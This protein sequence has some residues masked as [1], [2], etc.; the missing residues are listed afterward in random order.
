AVPGGRD[1]LNWLARV[2]TAVLKLR[3]RNWQP[4]R[5]RWSGRP[6]EIRVWVEGPDFEAP[7][8]GYLGV[9]PGLLWLRYLRSDIAINFS[10][11]PRSG[12][13]TAFIENGLLAD[14][15]DL[16]CRVN[17]DG[18]ASLLLDLSGLSKPLIIHC[19]EPG[20]LQRALLLFR[21]HANSGEDQ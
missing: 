8:P 2:A 18:T 14:P 4:D 9:Q 12:V 20:V 17:E 10:V 5:L 21:A 13:V 1:E 11:R 19:D 15:D 16:S 6:G 3:P 7:A